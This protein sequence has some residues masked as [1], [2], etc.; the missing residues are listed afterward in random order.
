LPFLKNEDLV[1]SNP[2]KIENQENRLVYR[3]ANLSEA[4]QTAA[5]FIIALD[6]NE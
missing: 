3:K 2:V 4:R 1:R 5:E 6:K